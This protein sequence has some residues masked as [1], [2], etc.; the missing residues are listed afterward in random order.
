MADK[1]I[2]FSAPMIRALLDRTKTQ[3]RR[4]LPTSHPK[5]PQLTQ[6]RTDVLT[7]L[8]NDP[9]AWYW[10]GVYENVG[11]SLRIRYAAGDRLWVREAWSAI[12]TGGWTIADARS[13]LFPTKIVYRADGH[14]HEYSDGWWPSI[15]MPREFSRLTLTVTDVR[16][17]RLQDISRGDAMAEGCPF[18]NMR[19][20]PD[21][22]AWYADL[23]D[24]INGP[25]A[26]GKNP[27]VAAYTFSVQHCNIDR[28]KAPP[29]GVE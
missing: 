1:P 17:Q 25:G 13:G 2:L 21:P 6:I 24:T 11:A 8:P 27:W 9:E 19:D 4:A 15:H 5:F 10:D 20:G 28:L 16:I 29:K 12:M 14:A 7:L 23:W 26:W 18:A 22:R 3:T